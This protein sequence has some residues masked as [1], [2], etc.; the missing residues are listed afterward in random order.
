MHPTLRLILDYIKEYYLHYVAVASLIATL[1]SLYLQ[2]QRREQRDQTPKVATGDPCPRTGNY[3]SNRN[4][5]YTILV[6]EGQPMPPGQVADQSFLE[7]TTWTFI[8]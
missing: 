1:Y 5:S 4:H 2:K 3:Q 7:D 8:E 6:Q